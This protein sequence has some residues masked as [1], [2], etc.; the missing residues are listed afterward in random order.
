MNKQHGKIIARVRAREETRRERLYQET[1]IMFSELRCMENFITLAAETGRL[2][3][4]PGS[5]VRQTTVAP[6]FYPPIRSATQI[7]P[8]KPWWRF[9]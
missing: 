7:E 6:C 5:Q 3:T 4:F 8:A 9:W 1:C 2:V